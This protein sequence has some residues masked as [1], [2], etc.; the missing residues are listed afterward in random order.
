MM[1]QSLNLKPPTAQQAGSLRGIWIH[2]CCTSCCLIGI[3]LLPRPLRRSFHNR[4]PLCRPLLTMQSVC[5]VVVALAA[6]VLSSAD[7]DTHRPRHDSN[8]EICILLLS[9]CRRM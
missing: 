7:S 9:A 8:L 6:A 4:A 1:C 5:A 2:S 3:F